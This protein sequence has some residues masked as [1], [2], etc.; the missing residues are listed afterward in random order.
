MSNDEPPKPIHPQTD[1]PARVEYAPA[2][3]GRDEVGEIVPRPLDLTAP[4]LTL[5][6]VL[7]GVVIGA[8]F[9][10]CNIYVGFK[11][12]LV[13]NM[14]ITAA[15]LSYG[16]WMGLHNLS[17]GRIRAWG[18]LEN[19]INQTACSSAASVASAGL[20]TAIPAL[21]ILTGR[22]LIWPVLA[23]WV[24]S[25]CLVGIVVAVGLRRQMLLTEKLTFPA[26]VAA[27]QTLREVYARGHGAATR[28][29]ALVAGGLAASGVELYKYVCAIW[30][31]TCL[32]KP[33]VLSSTIQGQSLASLTFA[34]LPS[35]LLLAVG[36]LIGFRACLSLLLGSVV[37]FG[38]IAPTLIS[39]GTVEQPG[40]PA[41]IKWLVWPGATL[42]VVSALTSLAFT[43]RTAL[44]AFAGLARRSEPRPAEGR[45]EVSRSV[46][47][48]GLLVV[49]LLSV[50]LQ[51]SL[52]SIY[53]WA[54]IVGVL[55]SFALA[56][57]AAR[58]SGE[59]GVTPV[60]AIGKVTQL[61]LGVLVPQS[62]VP[63]LMAANVTGGAASQCAD[64]LDD[65]K[66]GYLLGASPR[67][68]AL[69][70][71]FGAMVGA[72]A[73]A[74]A[75]TLLFPD[76][77]RQL[78]TEEFPAAAVAVWISV[79]ELFMSG[80]DALPSGTPTAMLIAAIVAV[81]LTTV[82]KLAPRR[83]RAWIPSGA[84]LGLAF[85]Y[86]AK[87]SITIF[88]GGLIAFL[89]SK[90][91]KSWTARFLITICAGIIAGDA[92]TQ[93]GTGIHGAGLLRSLLGTP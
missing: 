62:P 63:N 6:A 80:I 36:G 51:V 61:T 43:W 93:I 44:A 86:P 50:A 49:L 9:S 78:I 77:A 60:G 28:I 71:V 25:V 33:M 15:L 42:M 53:W 66:C 34:I 10:V 48:G 4:Q 83:V 37:A 27:A 38:V 3:V 32:L 26:G 17:G 88:L 72:L 58:V 23:F 67:L 76:P 22:A 29:L 7:T 19:N 47:V 40:F 90:W 68:Q 79:A 30:G 52:F 64:L 8:V 18:I 91:F 46:F 56:I 73:G 41:L 24:L 75:Y 81:I 1:E 5:R 82:E 70:Q 13:F 85:V 2:E 59:T 39:N 14:S 74:L 84:S 92:L 16:F 57:V 12:G 20:I 54:A 87:F 65:L 35:P 11:V 89:L 69:A 21:T 31:F 45:A 55:M